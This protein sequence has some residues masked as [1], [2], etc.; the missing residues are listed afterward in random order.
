MNG[1]AVAGPASKTHSQV[2]EPKWAG[3]STMR[4][5][6]EV[7]MKS[8]SSSYVPPSVH[9]ECFAEGC[10]PTSSSKPQDGDQRN[11]Y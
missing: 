8:C 1:S 10:L 3:I 4:L 2:R 6:M 5:S 9:S 11:S 7:G